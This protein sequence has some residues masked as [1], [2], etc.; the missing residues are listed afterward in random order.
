MNGKDGPFAPLVDPGGLMSVCWL[1]Q[2]CNL[3]S[4]AKAIS[5]A[6][7]DFLMEQRLICNSTL[8][9]GLTLAGKHPV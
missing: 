4:V 8:G 9:Q 3:L 5:G 7:R 2:G 6:W 1:G